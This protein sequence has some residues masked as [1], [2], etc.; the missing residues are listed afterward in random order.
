L[1]TAGSTTSPG[2]YVYNG[3]PIDLNNRQV[4]GPAM[5]LAAFDLN[6][7]DQYQYH[8]RTFSTTFPNLRQDATNE[9]DVSVLKNFIV[10]EKSY[11]QLRGEAYN[12]VNHPVFG[13]PGQASAQ[14]PVVAETNSSFGYITFQDNRSRSLQIGARFVF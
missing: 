2:D 6:S 9:W 12:V 4:N 5:N 1:W 11:L 13:A 10:T 3:Q 8:Y 7:A 14:G